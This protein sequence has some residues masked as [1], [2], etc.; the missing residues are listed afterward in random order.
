MFIFGWIDEIA[1]VSA[2]FAAGVNPTSRAVITGVVQGGYN[3]TK[4]AIAK[5]TGNYNPR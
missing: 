2:A 3:W 1:M 5:V 4:T